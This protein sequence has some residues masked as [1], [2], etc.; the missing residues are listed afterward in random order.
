MSYVIGIDGGTE[1]L[2]AFVFDLGGRLIASHAS[3]YETRFPAP[4]HA[5]Q[6]PDEWWRAIGE[7]T[8]GAVAEAGIDPRDVIALSPDFTCC[9][10]VALDGDFRPLRPALLWMDV[11]AAEE[12]EMVLAT[13]DPALR[14]NG[15]GHGPVSAEWMIPK[16][17]WIKRHEPQNYDR[18]AH[19]CDYQ[20]YMV[21]RLT[22]R[23][24]GSLNTMAIRWHYQVDHGGF[25]TSLLAALDMSELLE[26]WPR[27]VTRPGETVGGLTGEA[28]EH[29]GLRAGTPVAQGGADAFTGMI[30]LGAA[31]PGE[32]A[33]ITGS[34][35]L[36][37]AVT[38]TPVNR[39]GVWG[40][41]Q[42]AVYP[43]RS[44]L[45]GGQTSTG[46]II[47][48]FRREFVHD[49]DYDALNAEAANIPPGSDGL[50]ALDHFQGNRTPYTDPHSRGALIGL[51]LSHTAAHVYRAVIESICY[52]TRVIVDSFGDAFEPK[53][54]VLAG[55]AAHSPL[56]VQI[57]AD[58]LGVPVQL[59]EFAD[60]PALGCAVLAGVAG[61]AFDSID[62]GIAAMVRVTEV[63]EP[64]PRN[65]EIYA[66]EVERYRALYHAL[67][68]IHA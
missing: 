13:G 25:P 21:A 49:R 53:R 44:V 29:L 8:R 3:P 28:A 33:L 14:I 24:V 30:G 38:D 18:A 64:D 7:A 34:S 65:T 54:I 31:Q 45:E 26:K 15:A 62:D 48:W 43:G 2:R 51:S 16:A 57:H 66:A 22:G 5:E 11:R 20:D 42:D 4:S 67:K 19:I 9:T 46:S 60:A 10:V 47:N 52:G 36:Q 59:T 40:S 35:H 55:G 61:G 37:L 56:W 12:T 50:L 63:V 27:E 39:P 6:N 23:Y 41:Y 32:I 1:S 17:L 68:S 58:T